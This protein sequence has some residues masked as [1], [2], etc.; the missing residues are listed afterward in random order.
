M[1]DAA[2]G[3]PPPAP[4]HRPGDAGALRDLQRRIGPSARAN[5]PLARYASLRVGGPADLYLT[6]RSTQQIVDAVEAAA[7]LDVP[8]RIMGGASNLLI[9]D[10]GIAGLVIRTAANGV[11]EATDEQ[12]RVLIRAEAGRLLAGLG[13]QLALR[14]LRGLEWAANVPGTVGASVVNNSGAFGSC[15]AEHLACASVYVLGQGTVSF[16][17][18]GLGLAYRSSHLKRGNLIGAVLDATFRVEVDEPSVLRA[19]IS[20]IQRLRRDSQPSGYSIGSVFANPPGDAAGRLIE[21]AG[22]KGR[23]IGD[24]VVSQLHANFIVNRGAATSRDVLRLVA[25]VQTTVWRQT[26]IWLTPEVQLAGR[27][28]PEELLALAGP[29]GAAA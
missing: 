11:C 8:W 18:A 2:E 29:P 14:G 15:V 25:H 26:G 28:R 5:E 6:A 9:A 3:A 17:A 27:F 4:T 23:A 10:E 13:K 16:D 24:A 7:A 20:E 22:L 1:R 21:S 19:R 12:G